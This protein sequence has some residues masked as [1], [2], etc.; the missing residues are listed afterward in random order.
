[1][2]PA[3]TTS[4][5]ERRMLGALRVVIAD[6]GSELRRVPAVLRSLES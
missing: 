5:L 6:T 1:M 3:A 2:A 4:R